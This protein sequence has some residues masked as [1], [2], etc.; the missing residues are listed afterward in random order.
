MVIERGLPSW[1]RLPDAVGVW[2]QNAGG[3]AAVAIALVLLARWLQ[4]DPHNLQYWAL[5]PGFQPLLAI[6]KVCL[7][8]S[9]LGYLAMIL[10][11]VGGRSGFRWLSLLSPRVFPQ[12][13]FRIGDWILAVSGAL[14]MFVAL[15]PIAFDMLTRFSWRRI[16][17]IAR[18]SWKESIRGRVIWVFAVM[19]LVFLFAGWFVKFKP[20]DQVRIYVLVV[21]WSMAPLFLITA[22]LLGAFSI[23][24]DVRNNSIHTIVT[25]P[26]ERFE[27]VAGRFLG[28]AALLT[29]GLL[30]LSALSLIY[31]VRGITDE[32]KKESFT[33][34]VPI[35]GQ[36]HFA[37][38]KDPR[39][40]DDVGNAFAYRSYIKG[41]TTRKR[42]PFR[43][44][45]IWDFAHVP[46]DVAQR[47]KDVAF[48][49]R[50][51]IFRLSKGVQGKGV[52]C[53]FSFVN[54]DKF[55]SIDPNLQSQELDIQVTTMKQ[56]YELK[57]DA[58]RKQWD[59]A[60]KNEIDPTKLDEIEKQRDK[61]YRK[62]RLDLNI[63]YGI[64]ETHAELADF[65]TLN[66]LV[67]A[68]ALRH[69]LS[70]NKERRQGQDAPPPA[71]RVFLGVDVS[72][73]AQMVG[74]AQYD[75]YLL[76][77]E[78]DFWQNFLKGVFG[79]W[80]TC[81][82]VLG[83]AITCSTY[84]SGVISFL[85][86]MFLFL[87]GL[88]TDY[89]RE[90][91]EYRPNSGGGPLEAMIR[92]GGK[93]PLAGQL[94]SSPT[95]S[96]VQFLDRSFSRVVGFVLNLI[97]DINRHDLQPYV[98]NGFDIAWLDLLLLDNAIPVFGYLLPW[99]ILAYYLMKFREIANPS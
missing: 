99:A 52:F 43:Q 28:Y 4:R 80:C 73:E 54:V 70:Q 11:M 8:G 10:I 60:R 65:H 2:L 41:M 20:E 90:I 9:A 44:F 29:V 89:L 58:A 37:G 32:A 64:Y 22:G 21:Y 33:A 91:S 36:L 27:V 17:A 86:A 25:K 5:P 96:L 97:P 77:Y 1:D 12:E 81:M 98:A 76:A 42:E 39:K 56:E 61:D 53:T 46:A 30:I 93:I 45:A 13:P 16:W 51:D 92:L 88:F 15:T 84:L 26:V 14:A 59:D 85:I 7:I 78:R 38:T 66:V 67:P 63:E 31:V 75:F 6:L 49:F 95:T 83:V 55:K 24:N 68:E 48:E 57:R 79:M 62:I 69:I 47:D 34:R 94:E 72:E 3:V 82:L 23:P 71:L 40:G 50:F 35:Y 74:V 18:L 87:A 19:V